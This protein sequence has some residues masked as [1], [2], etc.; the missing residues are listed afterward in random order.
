[1]KHNGMK[2]R[3]AAGEV[4]VGT[5]VFEFSTTGI[6][7][8]AAGAGAGFIIYDME[9]TGWG[10]DT[11]RT[12]LASTPDSITPIVRVPANLPYLIG[13]QMDLGAAGVMVPMVESAEAAQTLAASTH[14]PPDGRRGAAFGIAHDDYV[15]GNIPAKVAAANEDVLTIAQIETSGGVE[16]V[17]AI[18]AVEGI[19]VLFLGHFDLTNFLGI[20]GQFDDE[21]FTE[22]VDRIVAAATEHG[23]T[24]ACLALT[25]DE[26]R[27]WIERGFRMITF[28][29]DLWLYQKALADGIKGIGA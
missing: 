27:R 15:G 14:Y 26:A 24:L 2:Q 5:M 6:G 8:L 19:D 1:M 29:G 25:V 7:R 16:N 10:S 4:V 12:L 17:D 23:K 22:S 21:R 20:P 9:H 3:L 13:Q 18:A 28:G 11:T